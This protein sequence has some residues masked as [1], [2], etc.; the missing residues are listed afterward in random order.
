MKEIKL[1]YHLSSYN[2]VNSINLTIKVDG[3][4][5][6]SLC[7]IYGALIVSSQFTPSLAVKYLGSKWTMVACMMCYSLYIG[8]QFYPQYYTLLPTAVLVGA[9]AAPLWIAKCNYLTKVIF[10][11]LTRSFF[12]RFFSLILYSRFCCDQDFYLM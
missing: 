11:Q 6:Y 2:L 7:L 8:A 1:R 5:T 12:M 4:G 9:A 3:L 10:A